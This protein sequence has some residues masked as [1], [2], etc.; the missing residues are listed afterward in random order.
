MKLTKTKLKQIIKEEISR[1]LSKEVTVDEGVENITPENLKLVYDVLVKMS[2]MLGMLAIGTPLLK[3]IM[4]KLE[5]ND[6]DEKIKKVKGGYK[7]TSK[8]GRELSKKPKSKEGAQAQLAAVE[9][10]K[11]KRGKK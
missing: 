7:A 11:A 4:D 5:K 8:S 9:I 1:E 6:L 10:S 2:P 3:V